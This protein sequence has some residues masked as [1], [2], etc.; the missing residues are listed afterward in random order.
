MATVPAI[1]FYDVVVA[2]HVMAIV[3][4]F[5]V[6]FVYPVVLPWLARTRPEAMPTAHE[7]QG[8][9][10]RLLI[11]PAATLALL[12]GFYLAWDA[13]VFSEVWVTVPMVILIVLLG[14]GGAFFAPRERELATIARRDLDAGGKLSE[15]YAA[16]ARTLGMVGV[17]SEVLVLIAI[18][19]MVAKPFA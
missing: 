14:L 12:T 9:I 19:F 4:A 7:V 17:L 1:L 6:T 3:A 13:D 5:G 10:G 11:T 2:L 8:R 18:F 16:R 15:E